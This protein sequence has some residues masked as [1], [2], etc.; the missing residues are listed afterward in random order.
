MV[1]YSGD[2]ANSDGRLVEELRVEESR[3]FVGRS[4]ICY[5]EITWVT[6]GFSGRRVVIDFRMTLRLPA[7]R[8]PKL[9]RLGADSCLVGP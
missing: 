2:N 1:W 3:K 6:E 8:A 4:R 5:I 9:A 7:A